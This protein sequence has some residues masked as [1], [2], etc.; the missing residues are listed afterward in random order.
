[1][2]YAII[3]IE[4]TGLSPAH[5]KITEIAIYIHDGQRIID[6]FCSLVN[7]EVKIP[8]Y[9]IQLTGINDKMVHDAPK[10][11][12][13]ARRIVEITEDCIIVAHS[14]KFDYNFI[15]SE[16]KRLGYEYKRKTLCTVKLS[17]RLLPGRKSYG[18]GKLCTE[19]GI[20]NEKRHRA[21]GDA[22]ATVKLF[23]YLLLIEKDLAVITQRGMNGGLP[24]EKIYNLPQECG[25]YYFYDADGNLIY[26]GKSINI[27]ERVISHFTNNT[28][29]KEVEMANL[30]H[31]IDYRLTGSELV[32]LLLESD[33]IKQHK[34]YYN[35][36]QRRNLFH[37]GV[38]PEYTPE[39]YLALKLRRFKKDIIPLT[40]FSSLEAG[41]EFLHRLT[42]DHELC[43]K[44][45]GIYESSGACFNA[46]IGLCRGACTGREEPASY[47]ARVEEALSRYRYDHDNFIVID[48]G[49]RLDEK[50]VVLVEK[51]VYRGFGFIDVYDT[52]FSS[53]DELK[54]S[55]QY[56]QDNRDVKQIIISYL[57]RNKI[58]QL[59]RF[60][61]EPY[62]WQRQ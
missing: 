44:L 50:S 27:Q 10:F 54:S 30:V 62:H 41:R 38:F 17:R 3:D 31:D 20:V 42:E 21:T 53:A 46:G 24:P 16:F 57:K 56:H 45:S 43:Q 22:L 47:N 49:R 1:M 29:K 58:E 28:V 11:Y 19:L 8:Y 51:G 13:I 26:I 25:V 33:E 12:E 59:V 61:D 35:R 37:Y 40:S 15:R 2:K 6:E 48:K 34:P 60:S 14:A 55:I 32:A 23:E 4:T 7:P 36:A 18:L 5:Q 39:G 9:I 52:G